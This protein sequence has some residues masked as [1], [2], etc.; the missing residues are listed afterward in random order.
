MGEQTK[1][2]RASGRTGFRSAVWIAGAAL[3][4][5]LGTAALAQQDGTP[6]GPPPQPPSQRD[7]MQTGPMGP[8]RPP[9]ERAF[10]LGPPGRWWDNPEFAQ[11]IGI[12]S[13]Q[14]KRMD[15][16]FQQSRLKLIDL[17]ASVEKQETILDPLISAD[18]PNEGQILKQIDA[19]AQARAEL[20]KANARMLLG[21]RGV[22]TADQWKKLQADEQSDRASR[23]SM[24]SDRGRDGR[25]PPPPG[26]PPGPLPG[27]QPGGRP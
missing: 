16:I 23:R 26:P 11:K 8:H 13:E 27:D 17:H 21:L 20:E 2:F 3:V 5:P 12:S 14:Q 19:V 4:W 1:V 25:T 9:M 7:A 18:Q 10:H 24:R 15:D 22:L 6:P